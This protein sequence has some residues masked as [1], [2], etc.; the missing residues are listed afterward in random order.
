MRHLADSE[1]KYRLYFNL[2]YS[3]MVQYNVEPRYTYNIDEKG[4]LMGVTTRTKRV[5]SRLM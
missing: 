2:I 5:F 4:F 1:T 3:K